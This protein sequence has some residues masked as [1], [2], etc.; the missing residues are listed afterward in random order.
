LSGIVGMFRQD[1]APVDRQ[2]LQALTDFMSY[3][4][5]DASEIWHSGEVGL[6]QTMLKTTRQSCGERQPASLDDR[7]WMTADAR[8]DERGA[9]ILLLRASGCDVSESAPDSE[10]VLRSYATWGSNCVGHLRG[11]FAFAIWDARAK[12]LFCAR[13]RFGIKPDEVVFVSSNRWDIMGAASFGFRTVWVNRAQMPQEYPHQPPIH[14]VPD[15]SAL[16]SLVF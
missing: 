8:L 7:I 1:G 13:D 9:L 6:G 14:T 12:V 2:L 16:P 5:P 4:G 15:L 10:L 3:R 11:D